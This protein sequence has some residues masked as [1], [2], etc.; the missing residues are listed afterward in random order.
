[1]PC[2]NEHATFCCRLVQIFGCILAAYFSVLA[3]GVNSIHS[4]VITASEDA[5]V[6][7][8]NGD[9]TTAEASRFWVAYNGAVSKWNRS[10]PS[11]FHHSCHLTFDKLIYYVLFWMYF[12]V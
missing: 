7:D 11:F 9:T 5:L 4:D 6:E 1:M 3:Y 10:E 8:V 2:K 12:L